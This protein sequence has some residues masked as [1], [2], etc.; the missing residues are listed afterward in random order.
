MSQ[1][2]KHLGCHGFIE[3]G[4]ITSLLEIIRDGTVM[5]W[6]FNLTCLPWS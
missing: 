2:E 4:Q 3:I 1:K 5:K 6:I